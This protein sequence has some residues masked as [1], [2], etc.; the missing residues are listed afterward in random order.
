M[1]TIIAF[2]F[3]FISLLTYSQTVTLNISGIEEEDGHLQV[4][5]F[6]T[7]E[8]FSDEKAAGVE[9]FDKSGVV[10]GKKSVK[11]NL[12]PGKYGITVLDDEDDNKNMTYR[13]GVYPLEGVGFSNFK[14]TGMSKP[15]FKDFEFEVTEKGAVVN[16]QMR[17]F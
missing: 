8:Q 11:L 1:K 9:Y 3:C 16:A 13:F 6:E 5:I 12:K 17:Y 15:D 10:D 7:E 2:I 4:A 14:F